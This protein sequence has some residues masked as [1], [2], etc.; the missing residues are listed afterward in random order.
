MI[1]EIRV[2]D[3]VALDFAELA[4]REVRAASAS[5]GSQVPVRLGASG[6]SSGA[7][8]FSSL[9]ARDDLDWS[10]VE[11]YFADERCVDA[12][13]PQSNQRAIRAALGHHADELHGF[14]PMSCADGPDA[15]EHLLAA[16]GGLDLL[17][18][19]F[20]PDGHTAS[21][22][23]GSTGLDAPSDRLVVA[24]VDP[25]GLNPLP[26]L[27]LTYS[28]IATAALVVMVVAGVEKR[29][30]LARLVAGE[31]LPAARVR[32]PRV[33]WLCDRAAA[34]GIVA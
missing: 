3:D 16:A 1:G 22:F 14:H 20:G 32:A 6:G 17:Q 5:R 27:S 13:A 8:C 21:L 34:E 7:S 25:S 23:P 31:D 24:N 19:G 12:D 18:L 2:V 4:V 15:Y 28:G 26:R 11:L 33:L 30:A 9:A 10:R 29:G